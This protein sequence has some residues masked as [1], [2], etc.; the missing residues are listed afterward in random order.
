MKVGDTFKPKN[1]LNPKIWDQEQL[2]GEIRERLMEIAGEFYEGL[3][4]NVADIDDITFTGSLANFNYTKFSDI[5]LH[6]LI[7]YKKIDENED[8]VKEYF[9]AK[10][11]LWN[12]K[13]KIMING[14]EV[15]IYV[16]DSDEPHHSSG[17]YSVENDGWLVKPVK[18]DVD[19]DEEIIDKKIDTFIGKIEDAVELFEDKKYE[20][21]HNF[22]KTTFEKI[23]KFR[24]TGLEREGEYSTENLTFKYLRNNGYIEDILDVRTQSYDKM[25]SIEGDFGKK[26]KIFVDKPKIKEIH[27][28]DRLN[29]LEKFQKKVKSRH[30]RMKKRLIALGNQKT[31]VAY[32]GKPSYKRSKSAPPGFG[33]T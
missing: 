5:D 15:E 26:Y 17:V 22:A 7:D 25:K 20:E 13:H 32:P 31:G 16:Q 4:L 33:G 30:Q 29:E 14:Y 9:R 24:Q 6:I 19:Y 28:F 21:A 2:K 18:S 3:D 23:K 10:S 27:G 1:T 12:Q 11:S 8:L